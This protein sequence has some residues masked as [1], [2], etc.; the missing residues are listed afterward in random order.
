MLSLILLCRTLR[1]QDRP[2]AHPRH[3]EYAS[4][5]AANRR[6]D[7]D[8]WRRQLTKLP[9]PFPQYPPLTLRYGMMRL[10]RCA[11]G[12]ACAGQWLWGPAR[13]FDMIVL[14]EQRMRSRLL[15][16]IPV[17]QAVLASIAIPQQ[18]LTCILTMSGSLS[19]CL[20]RCIGCVSGSKLDENAV[21]GI[22]V[23]TYKLVCQ[24]C[25]KRD[26]LCVKA[27]VIEIITIRDFNAP[28]ITAPNRFKRVGTHERR[29]I[30]ADCPCGH[31]ELKRKIVVCIMPSTAQHL[32]QLLPPF[33]R[34]HVF[35]PSP[36][37]SGVN[38]K[39]YKRQL[40]S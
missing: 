32:Y 37:L 40:L 3:R 2:T 16:Y 23:I 24:L 6:R 31:V 33:A 39:K 14:T 8:R 19:H 36:P 29:N 17:P 20:S 12:A 13:T 1:R 5:P 15:S 22:K 38:D 10:L 26:L 34:A 9:R 4:P 18:S 7:T 35:T 25:E 28:T 11:S 30:T 27:S 21:H